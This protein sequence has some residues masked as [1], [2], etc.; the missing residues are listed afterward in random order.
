MPQR[1]RHERTEQMSSSNGF[2]VLTRAGTIS[3]AQME[4]PT[5]ALYL[6]FDHHRKQQEAVQ[7]D[8]QDAAELKALENTLKHRLRK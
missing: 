8:Q 2:S 5:H 1:Q 4:S 6:A 7:A 3:H